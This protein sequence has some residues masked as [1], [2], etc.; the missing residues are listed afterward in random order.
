MKI[1]G[2]I[3]QAHDGSLGTAHALIDVIADAG[4]DIVK[5]QTHLAEAESSPGEPWRKAF[6]KQDETR[7][8]YWKRM[9]FSPDQ[10]AG[11]KR[12]VED[13]GLQ[14]LSSPFSEAAVDLLEALNVGLWKVASGETANPILLDR[15]LRTKKPILLSSGM[16][17]W[18]DLDWAVERIRRA[19]GTFAILQCTTAYPTAPEQVG[20]NLLAE[21]R[22]RYSCEVGLSDHSGTVFPGLAV[23][24]LG[25][26]W[27][28]VHVTLSRQCFGPDVAAS[29][30]PSELRQLVDGAR[31]IRQAVD[32]PAQKD[33]LPE[34]L[35]SLRS[36]FGQSLVARRDLAKG[37]VLAAEDLTCRKP[38]TGISV[39]EYDAMLGRRLARDV[40]QGTFLSGSDLA[41]NES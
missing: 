35:L 2:E 32:H 40:E 24:T 18:A 27:L 17:S 25:A 1:I 20:L 9:E 3:A 4:A 34:E 5:F 13:R 23:A 14:F 41:P 6:S 37:Q 16:S 19:D 39:R 31:W 10:W 33:A 28:E 7:F 12:H 26:E 22:E 11:L 30:T 38:G 36:I 21:L 8:D 29:V 15:M